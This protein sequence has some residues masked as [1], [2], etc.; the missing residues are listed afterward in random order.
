MTRH[1]LRTKKADSAAE[2]AKNPCRYAGTP[3]SVLLR[4][5]AHGRGS[6]GSLLDTK[7]PRF[8]VKKALHRRARRT[9]RDHRKQRQGRACSAFMNALNPRLGTRKMADVWGQLQRASRSVG[10]RALRPGYPIN[11]VIGRSEGRLSPRLNYVEVVWQEEPH[12][13]TAQIA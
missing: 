6:S 1:I 11:G 12:V 9:L 4:P 13:A 3:R 5:P 8:A 7:L 2:G 10:S